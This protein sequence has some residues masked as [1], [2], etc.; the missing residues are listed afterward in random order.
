MKKIIVTAVVTCLLLSTYVM[1]ANATFNP[2][3][4]KAYTTQSTDN[5]ENWAVII[6]AGARPNQTE[7]KTGAVP[8]RATSK[9]VYETFKQ[10]GYDDE[11]IYFLHDKDLSAEGADGVVSK[12][13]IEYAITE[14]LK[15]NS[16]SNDNCCIIHSGHGG[17]GLLGIWNFE[18]GEP[19][20]LYTYELAS[21][22]DV[23]EYDVFTILIDACYSGTFLH[24][25]SGENRIVIT[26]SSPSRVCI[27]LKELVFTYHFL[28]KLEKNV[29]YGKAWEY[30]DKQIARRNIPKELYP[31]DGESF[32]RI[33]LGKMFSKILMFLQN[34]QIDDNGDKK[35]HGT[36]LANKLPIAGDGKLA[37]R[38]YP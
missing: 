17:A 21:W 19:E 29:S 37:L 25:L 22:I 31:T 26:S 33:F 16:D 10:L 18:K 20:L 15:N 38:T 27:G 5:K 8:I 30:A 2:K 3:R 23:V 9:H 28:N 11:H 36:I 6:C 12:A 4:N 14:W 1:S 7:G 13:N 35:G 24:S 34:P 32:F